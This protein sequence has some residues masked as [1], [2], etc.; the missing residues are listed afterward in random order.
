MTRD[1]VFMAMYIALNHYQDPTQYIQ[2]ALAFFGANLVEDIHDDYVA[3]LAERGLEEM[4]HYS[5]VSTKRQDY[6]KEGVGV[7]NYGES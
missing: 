1:E 4:P 5:F 7:W 6:R 2:Q 3:W